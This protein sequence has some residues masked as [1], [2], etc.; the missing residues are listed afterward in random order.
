MAESPPSNGHLELKTPFGNVSANGTTVFLLVILLMV[1][2][3]SLWEHQKRAHEHHE[4]LCLMRLSFYVN[5]QV[6]PF[7]WRSVPSEYWEC[8]PRN[9]A[10]DK[11]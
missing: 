5:R 6:Q 11:P 1:G 3:A 10:E 9:M 8:L 4:L 7:N 2:G